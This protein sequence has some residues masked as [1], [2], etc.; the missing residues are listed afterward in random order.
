VVGASG[1]GPCSVRGAQEPPAAGPGSAGPGSEIG[2]G[3]PWHS[4]K[5][6]TAAPAAPAT[7]LPGQLAS[8]VA[9]GARGAEG[10]ETGVQKKVLEAATPV[11][12]SETRGRA[13]QTNIA[14]DRP[15]IMSHVRREEGAQPSMR[16]EQSASQA[17]AQGQGKGKGYKQLLQQVQRTAGV[18]VDPSAQP[19]LQAVSQE[20]QKMPEEQ[21]LGLLARL[22]HQRGLP[23]SGHT[24][25][26]TGTPS[27]SQ[28][29]SEAPSAK[30]P[31]APARKRSGPRYARQV[32]ERQ[33]PGAQDPRLSRLPAVPPL[34]RSQLGNRFF[35]GQS[36]TCCSWCQGQ[37]R[38]G[39]QGRRLAAPGPCRH[40]NGRPPRAARQR[41]C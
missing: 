7:S 35:S 16:R 23:L 36:G 6:P 17:Q 34:F 10:G 40:A 26:T 1:K 12:N 29:C 27:V 30:Q 41:S 9:R 11:K 37:R 2:S 32:E 25:A 3:S 8:E 24:G 31:E 15:E 14:P 28:P 19:L 39:N 38:P 5:G 20:L 22:L 21:L 4:Q 13:N 18:A 33:D